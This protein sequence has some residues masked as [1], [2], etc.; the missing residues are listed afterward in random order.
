[1]SLTAVCR[2]MRVEIAIKLFS[3]TKTTGSLWTAAKFMASWKSPVLVDAS[4]PNA[5]TMY[6]SFRRFRASA[7][8]TACGNSVPT[9]TEPDTIRSFGEL[10][11]LR[12]RSEEHTS[13]LQS[14][15]EL[16]CR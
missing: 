9:H 10:N 16:V 1:M 7:S 4:P 14:H 15:H 2:S 8:P 3:M 6:G 12:N 13:E 11:M 5:K